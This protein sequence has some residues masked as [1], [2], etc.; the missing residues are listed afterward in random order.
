MKIAYYIAKGLLDGG[1]AGENSSNHQA[2]PFW[3]KIWQL[4]PYYVAKR[5][6]DGGTAGENSLN[7]QAS[8]FWKK[9][10]QLNVT[11]KVKIFAWRVCLDGL[12][13]MLNLRHRG[14]NT[15]GFCQICDKDLESINHAL[16]HFNH[17]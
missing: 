4:S 3:K 10:W 11:P 6:L 17:A 1:T 15:S 7:H 14:L 16:L 12:P 9:I 13:T 8:P 2:S 5:L